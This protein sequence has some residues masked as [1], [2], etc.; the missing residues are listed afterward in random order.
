M[1]DKEGKI[2]QK[3]TLTCDVRKRFEGTINR[4][5]A[6]MKCVLSVVHVAMS[7]FSINRNSYSVQIRSQCFIAISSALHEL[8]VE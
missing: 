8:P 1:P 6:E 3:S 4:F 7:S 5:Q 2:G